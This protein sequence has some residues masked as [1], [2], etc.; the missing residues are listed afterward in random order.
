[1]RQ[2]WPAV[3]RTVLVGTCVGALIAAA[4]S[5]PAATPS[6]SVLH[7]AAMRHAYARMLA[8]ERSQSGDDAEKEPEASSKPPV[9]NPPVPGTQPPGGNPPVRGTTPVA[10]A[11]PTQPNHGAGADCDAVTLG[12]SPPPPQS[13]GVTV[14][15]TAAAS[16]CP[17]P[18]YEFWIRPP[19][20][21]W[22]V[23]QG[24]S[25]S[26]TANWH[27]AGLALGTYEFDVWAREAGDDEKDVQISRIA[28]YGLQ[29]STAC[30][31]VTWNLSLIHI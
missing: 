3:G 2:T 7:S 16:R 14:V 29:A 17:S 18:E 30:T 4:C 20:G 12:A 25:L 22:S 19:G 8:D 10:G 13:A 27:T 11:Q 24:F 9:G 15:L 31:S 26:A 1:L 23:L 6:G 5:T 21:K 28:K